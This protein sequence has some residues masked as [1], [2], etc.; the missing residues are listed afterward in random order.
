[1]ADTTHSMVTKMKDMVVDIAGI[2]RQHRRISTTSS[3]RMRN[4]L[5][6]EP[7][8]YD[9]PVCWSIR[10]IFDTLDGI[11]TMTDDIQELLPRTW[12]GS[13]RSCRRWSR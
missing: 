11:D 9:I 1:M 12:S 10:S 6:W 5:Y 13:T 2:A 8:C 4:Y 7:H 3:G